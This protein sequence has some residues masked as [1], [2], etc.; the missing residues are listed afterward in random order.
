MPLYEYECL[1]CRHQ[2]EAL[3]R[4]GDVPACPAC[5]SVELARLVSGFAV[6]SDQT[7]KSARAAGVKHQAKDRRD[8]VMADIEQRDHHDH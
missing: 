8:K 3:V 5:K 7:R 4:T 6:N 1:E 2:F